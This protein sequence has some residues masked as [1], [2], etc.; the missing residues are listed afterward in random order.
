MNE[1]KRENEATVTRRS[2]SRAFKVVNLF[3]PNEI[4]VRAPLD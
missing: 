3:F 4:F 2:G 1:D